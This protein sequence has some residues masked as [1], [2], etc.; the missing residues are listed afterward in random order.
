[1][2]SIKQLEQIIEESMSLKYIAQAYTEISS[3]KLKK[4]RAGIEKNRVFSQDVTRVLH[5]VKDAAAKR[6][7]KPKTER[8]GTMSVVITSNYRFTGNLE[9]QLLRFFMVNSAKNKTER[10]VIGKTGQEYLRSFGY[11]NSYDPVV[12]KK[13]LPGSQELVAL[14]AKLAKYQQILVYHAKMKSVLVQE[15]TVIDI[16][17]KPAD[18]VL[19]DKKAYLDYIFEPEIDKIIDFFES[20]VTQLLFEQTFLESELARTAA[21]LISMDSAQVNADD[22]IHKQKVLLGQARK[23]QV[24][25][26]LLETAASLLKWRKEIKDEE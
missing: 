20:Q 6:H 3:T 23:S 25:M 9:H 22:F 16:T 8:Q 21:R 19:L 13:D 15:P 4:I 2:P 18:E 12:F 14:N 7:I 11:F 5:I 17:Q 24:N 26:Q 10:M 1:M